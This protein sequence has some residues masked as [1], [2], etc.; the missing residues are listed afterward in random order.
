MPAVL[1][2]IPKGVK[3]SGLDVAISARN[4]V[5]HDREGR[6]GRTDRG[7]LSGRSWLGD[8]Y[9]EGIS[10]GPVIGSRSYRFSA[11]FR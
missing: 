3:P 10:A 6:I 2:I 8:A 11:K 1:N 9:R 4:S 5:F 7:R